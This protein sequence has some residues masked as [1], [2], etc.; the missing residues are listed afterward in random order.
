MMQEEGSGQVPSL[1][2]ERAQSECARPMRAVEGNLGHSLQTLGRRKRPRP[3]DSLCS[4][5]AR[6]RKA[7]V[8][9]AHDGK[10]PGRASN[11]DEKEGIGIDQ[12]AYIGIDLAGQKVVPLFIRVF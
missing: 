5:N 1:L 7:L 12:Y 11:T 3:G 9:R 2:A 10:A 8:G 6:P 4:R